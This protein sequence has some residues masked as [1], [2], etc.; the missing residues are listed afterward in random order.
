MKNIYIN[1]KLTGSPLY[2]ISECKAISAALGESVILRVTENI[3]ISIDQET[4]IG[5]AL[6][7]INLKRQLEDGKNNH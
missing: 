1:I 3:L 2:A 5:D 4:K 6:E 7:I